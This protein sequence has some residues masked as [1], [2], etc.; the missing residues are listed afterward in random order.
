MTPDRH[1]SRPARRPL[2]DPPRQCRHCHEQIEPV[3]SSWVHVGTRGRFGCRDTSSTLPL[4]TSAEPAPGGRVLRN[5]VRGTV[6]ATV[7]AALAL[8]TAVTS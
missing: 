7:V 2:A 5:P 8:G 4:A 6:P 1:T 3:G